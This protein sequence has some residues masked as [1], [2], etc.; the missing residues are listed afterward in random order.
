[1]NK[2]TRKIGSLSGAIMLWIVLGAGVRAADIPEKALASTLLESAGMKAGLCVHIGFKDGKLTGEL[3]RGRRIL[4]HGLSPDRETVRK[5]RA[6]LQ[7]E[8]LYG[9]A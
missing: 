9:Q 4:V 7:S 6:H 1:M 5:A 8:Q 3:S 2:P